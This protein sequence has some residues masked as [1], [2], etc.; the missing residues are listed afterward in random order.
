M[1]QSQVSAQLASTL[2]TA[3][4]LVGSRLD[5]A[6][7]PLT[8]DLAASRPTSAPPRSA[9]PPTGVVTRLGA[10]EDR[11]R[12]RRRERHRRDG[13][14]TQRPPR[15]PRRRP[16][17]VRVGRDAA[18]GRR[19]RRSSP[20]WPGRIEDALAARRRRARAVGDAQLPRAP[21]EGSCSTTRG[22]PGHRVPAVARHLRRLVPGR[23]RGPRPERDQGAAADRRG[24]RARGARRVRRGDR[25]RDR[26]RQG[27]LRRRRGARRRGRPERPRDRAREHPPRLHDAARDRSSRASSR[28]CATPSTTP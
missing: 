21:L 27:A 14:G 5:A 9:P 2:G 25:R 12:R 4:T 17:R 13:H 10:A 8:T 23:R 22:Q 6:L 28:R 15:R 11:G 16:R 3:A 18:P 7:A 20:T 1:S 24:H 26:R 19:S